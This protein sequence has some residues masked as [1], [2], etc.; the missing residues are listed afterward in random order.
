MTERAVF[1]HWIRDELAEVANQQGS[2]GKSTGLGLFETNTFG[3]PSIVYQ[4]LQRVMRHA[5]CKASKL[6]VRPDRT[7]L[8]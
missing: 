8:R 5:F 2:Y 1:H 6:G 4:D 7:T 3:Q